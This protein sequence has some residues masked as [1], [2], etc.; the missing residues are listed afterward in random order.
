MD[1]GTEISGRTI[2]MTFITGQ[3]QKLQG[4]MFTDSAN[5]VM[6]RGANRSKADT[7]SAW[8]VKMFTEIFRRPARIFEA[9]TGS[10]AKRIHIWDMGAEGGAL[11]ATADSPSIEIKSVAPM[12][13]RGRE[14]FQVKLRDFSQ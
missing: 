4:V 3:D 11:V 9:N 12:I 7:H 5:G 8:A 2:R 14:R 6:F 1:N 13:L 10:T